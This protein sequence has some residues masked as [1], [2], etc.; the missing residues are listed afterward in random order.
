MAPFDINGNGFDSIH[1]KLYNST[2]VVRSG[3]V[4]YLDAADVNSYSGSGST[5]YDLSGNGNNGT[6]NSVDWSTANGGIFQTNGSSTSYI[7][8]PGPNLS[9][10]DY[11]VIGAAR[12]TGL[13]GDN[14][15]R[16]INAKVNNWLMGHW[17]N[18]V[19][20]YYA[21]GWVTSVGVGGTDNLWRIYAA[22]GRGTYGFYSNGV[23]NTSNTNGTE[24]PNGFNIGKIGYSTTEYTNGQVGFLLAYNRIL[25]AQEILQNY[26]VFRPRYEKYFDCGYGC[27][28]YSYDPGCT[29]C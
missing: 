18:S 10:S 9:S 16:M 1:A 22:T 3:L 29:A 7:D 8:I 24:G 12:Y 5:W 25:S 13:G 6:L 27:Q 2:S 26:Q 14:R 19:L 11:T 28:L 21:V 15:G 17:G 4:L 20:N 23:L